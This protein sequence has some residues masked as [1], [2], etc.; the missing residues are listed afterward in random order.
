VTRGEQRTRFAI[1]EIDPVRQWKLSP[2]DIAL[3]EK[4]DDYTAAKNVI[5]GR[6]HSPHS[7]WTVVKSN[8]KKRARLEAMRSLLATFDYEGRDDEVVGTPDPLIVGAPVHLREIDP[9]PV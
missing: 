8:D 5:F 3:L 9:A 6:T 7:P 1:R 2:T 4:W